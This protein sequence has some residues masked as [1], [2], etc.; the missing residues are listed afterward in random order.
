MS[1]SVLFV[2]TGNICRSPT[3]EGIFRSM[4][5]EA[6]LSEAIRVD[7]VGMIAYHVGEKADPRSIEMARSRGYEMSD[8]RA[9][10]INRNDLRDFDWIIPMDQGHESQ[11]F[12]MAPGLDRNRVRLLLS[13]INNPITLDVPDPYY[14]GQEGFQHTFDLIEDGLKGLLDFLKKEH[15]L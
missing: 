15:Q 1:T 8:L 14:G 6:G 5:A 12:E 3:A 4:V 13:F 9:R 7:S 2:C 11:I 10:Q